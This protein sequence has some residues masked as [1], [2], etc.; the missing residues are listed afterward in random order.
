M[1]QRKK[2]CLAG[3]AL[4]LGVFLVVITIGKVIDIKNKV[5]QTGNTITVSGTGDVF[6]KP[7]LVLTTFSVVTEAKTVAE[8]LSQ[9]SEKMNGVINFIKS[10]GI[11]E[12]DLKTVNFNISPRYEWR[13]EGT[14]RVLVGY[15]VQQSLQIKIRVLEKIGAIIEG[16][17]VAGANQAGDLQFTIDKEDE[18][19]SQAREE[20]IKQAKEKAEE[21]AGQLGIK[22][23]KIISFSESGYRDYAPISFGLEKAAA[24]KIETGENKIEVTVSIIYEIR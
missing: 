23:V 6:A 19:K 9:N 13:N 15:E 24:P 21:L 22:L 16:A 7:D 3:F 18:L 17:T 5:Q 8:A 12:K 2:C 20:A 1:L 4:V 11:E 14:K 10:Q